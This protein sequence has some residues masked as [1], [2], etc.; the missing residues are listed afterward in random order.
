M[1]TTGAVKS[2]YRNIMSIE[3]SDA[4]VKLLNA[5]AFHLFHLNVNLSTQTVIVGEIPFIALQITIKINF[6]SHKYMNIFL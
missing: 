3:M 5:N 4:I 6:F 2:G 1:R